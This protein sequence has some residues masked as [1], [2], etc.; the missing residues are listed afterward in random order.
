MQWFLANQTRKE[1]RRVVL[2]WAIYLGLS[3][4]ASNPFAFIIPK[5]PRRKLPYFL[6]APIWNPL[7][8]L[9]GF[10]TLAFHVISGPAHSFGFSSCILSGDRFSTRASQASPPAPLFHQSSL[11]LPRRWS[12]NKRSNEFSKS[13]LAH[14]APGG[15]VVK[16]LPLAQV[17]IPGS[18]DLE[19]YIRLPAGSLLL[20]LPMS[21]PFSGS[22]LNK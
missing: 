10:L 22:L 6:L 13:T 8:F 4:F 12:R 14:G 11:D 3:H 15:S 9:P 21:L 20:P 19:S 7:A 18:W 5:L 17:E 1:C 2:F 16:C